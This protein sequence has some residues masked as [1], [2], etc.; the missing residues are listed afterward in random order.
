MGQT[1]GGGYLDLVFKLVTW[2]DYCCLEPWALFAVDRSILW[3]AIIVINY[4][5]TILY[6][7]CYYGVRRPLMILYTYTLV[8]VTTKK[9][10]LIP[11][12]LAL[13]ELEIRKSELLSFAEPHI[14]PVINS[15]AFSSFDLMIS[16]T[17]FL[18]KIKWNKLGT[19]I[20]REDTNEKKMKR[21]VLGGGDGYSVQKSLLNFLVYQW[22]LLNCRIWYI[23]GCHFF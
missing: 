5:F 21:R 23:N 7:A 16:G 1:S 18:T 15:R 11:T 12:G 17:K 4:A 3:I 8:C 20:I 9:L 14:P 13:Q 19:I 2:L 22:P 6:Q 10:Q